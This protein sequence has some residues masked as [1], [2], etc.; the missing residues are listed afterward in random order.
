[1]FLLK[2]LIAAL[3]LPPAGPLLVALLGLC[4]ARRRPRAGPAGAAAALVLLIAASLPLVG[5]RL[6]RSLETLPPIRADQLRS[7]QAIVVLG[8]G[9]YRAAPE[10]GG[11]TVNRNTLLRLR[12]AAVLQ[13]RSGLPMLVSGGAPFGGRPEA[14]AMRA[15]LETDFAVPVRWVEAASADTAEN[16]ANSAR[17]LHAAGV[18]RIA[19]VSQAW[20]LPRAVALFERQG[21]TVMAAPTGFSTPSPSLLEDL[22][23]SAA[24]LDRSSTALHEWLGRLL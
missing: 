20:H 15:V 23:P 10:Y 13:R 17:L 14:E 18:Q 19:L 3:I 22:L 1:M 24:A 12:Y 16:A 21:L 7:A 2:K 11:D 9:S 4:W 8:G 6:L 5:D